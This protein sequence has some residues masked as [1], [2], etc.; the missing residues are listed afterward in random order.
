MHIQVKDVD[1]S[2]FDL[3]TPY[4][5]TQRTNGM[6]FEGAS[7]W[8]DAAGGFSADPHSGSCWR[9]AAHFS[10][11]IA[12]VEN[13]LHTDRYYRRLLSSLTSPSLL[14]CSHSL[15]P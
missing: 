6:H 14:V 8:G 12:N 3:T 1:E 11:A 5:E 15:Y 9:G 2:S 13:N 4:R 7:E 10:W